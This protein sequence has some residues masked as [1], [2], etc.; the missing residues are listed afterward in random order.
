MSPGH[1]GSR[2]P[3]VTSTTA[4][5]AV[6]SRRVSA[7]ARDWLSAYVPASGWGC[8]RT[9]AVDVP[10][11]VADDDRAI[12]LRLVVR[13]QL[14]RLLDAQVA[15]E[16]LVRR[17]EVTESPG[18][19]AV[20]GVDPDDAFSRSALVDAHDHPIEQFPGLAALEDSLLD[21]LVILIDVELG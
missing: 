6:G 8:V 11:V 19:K 21:H 9:P 13:R 14:D 7:A 1:S 17:V 15:T 3:T 18:D 20:Y 5:P 12:R 10:Q 2:S 16:G 4:S